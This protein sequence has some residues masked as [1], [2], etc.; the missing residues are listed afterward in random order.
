VFAVAQHSADDDKPL[1]YLPIAPD[2]EHADDVSLTDNAD[3]VSD[4]HMGM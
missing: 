1:Y 4:A 3:E 2:M